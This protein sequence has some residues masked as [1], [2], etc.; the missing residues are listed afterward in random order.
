MVIAQESKRIDSNDYLADARGKEFETATIGPGERILSFLA[1][2][3]MVRLERLTT[4]LAESHPTMARRFLKSDQAA[5][6]PVC[7][8]DEIW[9]QAAVALCC[10]CDCMAVRSASTKHRAQPDGAYSG[11]TFVG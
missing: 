9:E 8:T 6:R 11:L 7:G 1:N 10:S 3:Q 2:L 4:V 5:T